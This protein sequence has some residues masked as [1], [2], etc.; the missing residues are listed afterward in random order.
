MQ[1]GHGS[2]KEDSESR[3][4][5]LDSHETLFLALIHA[6]LQIDETLAMA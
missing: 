5:G 1:S 2:R 3:N 6:G 4:S